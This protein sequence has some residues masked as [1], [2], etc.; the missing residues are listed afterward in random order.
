ML[1]IKRNKSVCG[2]TS[3]RIDF[4]SDA[5]PDAPAPPVPPDANPILPPA[6]SGISGDVVK[7]LVTQLRE[8]MGREMA[9]LRTELAVGDGV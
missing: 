1:S 8:G 3:G 4:A 6:P 9:T 5:R 7:I 2:V